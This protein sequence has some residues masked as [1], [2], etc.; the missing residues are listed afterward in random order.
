MLALTGAAFAAGIPAA[1][2]PAPKYH[3]PALSDPQASSFIIIPDTQT[4]VRRGRNQPL[5][6][7]MTAWIAENTPKLN[8][9]FV[10]F[11]GDLVDQNE[12]LTP[13]EFQTPP[14]P[15][16]QGD[17]PSKRQWESVARS[18]ARLDGVVPYV[19]ATGNH[20]YGHGLSSAGFHFPPVPNFGPAG[21]SCC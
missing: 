16:K 2:A 6:E 4:Y 10:L 18:I 15:K 8:I 17:Q 20:D 12:M 7:L 5:L 1:P 19:T 11:T 3:P 21:F 9:Q 14:R 13:P